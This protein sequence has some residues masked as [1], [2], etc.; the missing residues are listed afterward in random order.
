MKLKDQTGTNA[1]LSEIL[2]FLAGSASIDLGKEDVGR[3]EIKFM[4]SEG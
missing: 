1:I 4:L 2:G 3:L